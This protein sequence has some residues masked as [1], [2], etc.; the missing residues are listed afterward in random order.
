MGEEASLNQSGE[1]KPL[2]ILGQKEPYLE[3]KISRDISP[4][5]LK[6]SRDKCIGN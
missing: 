5:L 1:P 6:K 4:K 3:I 2:V